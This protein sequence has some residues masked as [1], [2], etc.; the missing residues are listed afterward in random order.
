M[1]NIELLATIKGEDQLSGVLKNAGNA[2]QGL[3]NSL[4]NSGTQLINWGKNTQWLGKQLL[5]NVTMPIIGVAT[6]AVDL[7]FTFDQAMSK[8]KAAASSTAVISQ[9]EYSQMSQ[10]VLDASKTSIQSAS[11]IANGF[12]ELVSA[13]Y[14]VS[15]SMKMLSTVTTFATASGLDMGDAAQFASA[16]LHAW[17]GTGIDLNQIMDKTAIAV[18]ATQLHF[19]DFTHGAELAGAMGKAAGQ[20]F[21]QM[22][23]ALMAMADRGVVAG[24]MGFYLRTI[25]TDLGTAASKAASAGIDLNGVFT[26]TAGNIRP[27][28]DIAKDLGTK[29]E[30]VASQQDRLNILIKLF[31]VTAASGMIPILEAATGHEDLF[32]S[33]TAKS[34]QSQ[35]DFTNQTSASAKTL[36]E[37]QQMLD[38]ST[39]A[40]QRM[41]NAINSTDYAKMQIALNNLKA[42]GIEIG[43]KL[44]P[45]LSE[46]MDN[47]L[48]P[49]INKFTNLNDTI[50]S[51]ILVIAGLVAAIGPF[52]IVLASTAELI[53]AVE[54]GVGLAS[55]VIGELQYYFGVLAIASAD[56]GGGIAGFGAAIDFAIGP[57]GWIIATISIM[58]IAFIE[59]WKHCEEFRNSII[60]LYNVFQSVL[61]PIIDFIVKQF[62]DLKKEF[63]DLNEVAG[64]K[65]IIILK[66]V[67]IT[68]GIILVG[69][70][71]QLGMAISIIVIA[72]TGLVAGILWLGNE[73]INLSK[74]VIQYFINV[75]Q[76]GIKDLAIVWNTMKQDFVAVWNYIVT[77]IAPILDKIFVIMTLPFRLAYA[78]IYGIIYAQYLF[79]KW[80]WSLIGTDITTAFTAV[81]N[82][83]VVIFTNIYNFWVTI[84]TIIYNFFVQ[85]WQGMFNFL[86]PILTNIWNSIMS[87]WTSISNFL[88]NTWNVLAGFFIG[89]Y[90]TI[91]GAIVR[92][93]DDAKNY[94]IGIWNG[95]SSSIIGT[96]SGM[97]SGIKRELNIAIGYINKV[98]TG[99]NKMP[100]TP[101]I[102]TLQSLQTGG[103][104]PSTGMYLMHQGER[105]TP[106]GSHTQSSGVIT[107]NAYFYGD[108]N[109]SAG[110]LGDIGKKLAR[111]LELAKMGIH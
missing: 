35:D 12:Y 43:E 1:A 29:L 110:D 85:I 59:L 28:S 45:I 53:G 97:V 23:I 51:T 78:I 36:D 108:V 18:Q 105:I 102:P 26:D 7:A 54:V 90:N 89:I 48:E 40:A 68:L 82:F 96:T 27:L 81:K 8:V 32:S 74:I 104:I 34:I 84:L 21:D 3:G 87:I 92:P 38:N 44:L 75:W 2:A 71:I 19:D 107:V 13:G 66:D 14:S 79:F 60:G 58:I 65:L 11:D 20:D 106:E 88:I 41:N 31:G 67:A 93:F 101:N 10:A 33:A 100:F 47:Y 25:F 73:V 99:Y 77:T 111:S 46:L 39:G 98:I 57:V 50:Q 56:A 16:Q 72:I 69:S 15:D 63:E 24:R 80:I 103:I 70:I 55:K 49:L 9:Q 52:L 4:I 91:H 109:E 5:Y 61:S 22:T 37:Y 64:G 42:A 86:M 95:L 94:L 83:I 6:A 62:N 17:A 30:G 76:N